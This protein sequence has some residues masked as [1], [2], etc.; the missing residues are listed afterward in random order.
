MSNRFKNFIEALRARGFIIRR[1]DPYVWL[2]NGRLRLTMPELLSFGRRELK[3]NDTG[4]YY[5]LQRGL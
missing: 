5:Q 4:L 2:V 1:I 3:K